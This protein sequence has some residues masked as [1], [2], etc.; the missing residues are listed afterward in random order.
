MGAL[1]QFKVGRE[2]ELDLVIHK[3]LWAELRK[4]DAPEADGDFMRIHLTGMTGRRLMDL[5]SSSG[6]DQYPCRP[7]FQFDVEP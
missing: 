4:A 1:I 2:G 7:I 5:T 3:A 6:S